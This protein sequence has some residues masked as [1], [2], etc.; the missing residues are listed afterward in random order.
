MAKK[1]TNDKVETIRKIPTPL[2]TS[3]LSPGLSD[4]VKVSFVFPPGLSD[5]FLLTFWAMVMRIAQTTMP[6]TPV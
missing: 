5:E 3:S 4:K 6:A 1:T 2:M